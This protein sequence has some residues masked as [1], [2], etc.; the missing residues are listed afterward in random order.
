MDLLE[1]LIPPICALTLSPLLVGIITRTK[2]VIAGRKGP[3]LLQLYYD[4]AKLL[5][6][7]VVYSVT[8]S[9]IF[10]L[11]P[12][13]GLAGVVMISFLL[14]LGHLSSLHPFG[15]DFILVAGIFG[16]MRFFT[17]LGALDTGSAFEGMGASREA[18]FSA[19]AEPALFLGIAALVRLTGQSSLSLIFAAPDMGNWLLAGPVIALVGVS[20][21]IVSLAENC[22]IPVDDPTTHLELTMI[23][24]VMVLDYSGPDL[25][26]ILYSSSTKLWLLLGIVVSTVTPVHFVN[27]FAEAFAQCLM[28]L[29]LGVGIGLVESTMARLRLRSVPALLCGSMV[30]AVLAI[31]FVLRTKGAL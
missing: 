1:R 17:I 3:P 2:A 4:C 31:G 20:L 26:I 28:L 21:F 11:A 15:G 23:H 9:W 8:T 7:G 18:L 10:R 14:P 22:R 25:G 27:P 6:R 5:K 29:L 19:L 16:L 13:V 30:L 24:E 12:L